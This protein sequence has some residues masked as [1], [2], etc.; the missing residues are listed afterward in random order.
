VKST[1][2]DVRTDLSTLREL[3]VRFSRGL[4]E[5]TTAA[6]RQ[7]CH[8]FT[9]VSS[10][11]KALISKYRREMLLRKRL[12]NQ[13]VELRG[14]IRVLCRMRPPI[15]EDGSG[16]QAAIVARVD[17]EDDGILYVHSKGTS[18]IFELDRVFGPQSS[19]EEVQCT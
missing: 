2:S 15:A 9:S 12:H 16:S 17:Q 10:E 11:N 7:I 1:T 6:C 5:D 14:N 18:K 19:Q 13:L 3:A 8:K 4:Y